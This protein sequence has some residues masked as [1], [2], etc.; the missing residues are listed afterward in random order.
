VDARAVADRLIGAERDRTTIPPFTDSFP[1]LRDEQ[2]YAAQWLVVQDRLDRGERIVGAKL[3]MTSRVVQRALN[4]AEPVYG[5]L[6]SDVL[7]E[8]GE[9]LAARR[10]VQPR[11][12]P[13][14]ALLLGADLRAPTTL[15][16]VLAATEAVLGAVEVLDSRYLDYRYRRPDV[17]ADNVGT[18]AVV[19]G[20][21]ARRPTDLDDLGLIGCTF[22]SRGEVVG[23]ASG[24]AAMGHPAAAV[25]WLVNSLGPRG[26]QLDAGS[27][28]LTGGLV[29]PVPLVAGTEVRA[30][31]YG[32]G[33][34]AVTL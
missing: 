3:G 31:F 24:A 14:I 27:L 11:A 25:A 21:R 29:G 9:P 22:R 20:T 17:I 7:V 32:L 4:V 6:T 34:V 8:P 26:R 33:A 23:T 12:E 5:W 28:V 2:A 10:L 18:G 16:G 15:A 1:F 19:L 30:E 13:E